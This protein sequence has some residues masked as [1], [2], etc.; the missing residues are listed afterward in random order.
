MTLS[1]IFDDKINIGM[2]EQLT[3]IAQ[4]VAAFAAAAPPHTVGITP[5]A[6]ILAL[7]L[8]HALDAVAASGKTT[9]ITA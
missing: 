2:A 8:A 7:S 9:P 5:I 6:N 1:A 4:A 3:P